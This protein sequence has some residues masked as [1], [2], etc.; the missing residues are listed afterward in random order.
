M[1]TYNYTDELYHH[2]IKGMKWGIR[3]FQNKD[4]SL[5]PAGKKRYDDDGPTQKTTHRQ[6]LEEKYRSKGM[7]EESAKIAANKRIK[8][9]KIIAVTAGVTIAAATAYAANKYIKEH[10]DGI[11]K[12]G[13]K[14]QVIATDPNK[15]LDRPFY[16]AY[17]KS[18]TVKYKGTLGKTFKE[19]GN[20]VHKIT[21]NADSDVKIASR[22]KAADTFANLYKTDPEFREAFAKSNALFEGRAD[23]HKIA[24]GKMTDKQLKR[25]GYDAFNIGLVNHDEN[26]NAIAKKF[27]DKLKS[28]GYDAVMDINDQKYSGYYSKKPV[29]VFNRA[30]K[31][32]LS[33]VKQM[34]DEQIASNANKA[35]KDFA[36]KELA[37]MGAVYSGIGAANVYGKKTINSIK[38]DNYRIEHPGTKK[39]DK[40][41]LELLTKSG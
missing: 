9:E 39:T 29:I 22:Q 21:L 32:S 10:A 37:K 1:W 4:G 12:S 6:R 8:I 14:M 15:N 28:Q 19:T 3:R 34:T 27:Y 25:A 40:E 26:G 18:D 2:G 24:S 17:K 7:S 38:V 36:F 35:I 11:I 23:V 16:A 13:T 5:T 30:N 20:S 41:I 33:D 31:I